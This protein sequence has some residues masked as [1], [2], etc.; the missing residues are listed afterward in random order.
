MWEKLGLLFSSEDFKASWS[1]SHT[2]LPYAVPLNKEILRVFVSLRNSDNKSIVGFADI[3][4]LPSPKVVNFSTH[5]VLVPGERGAFDQDGISVGSVIKVHDQWFFYY[6][7]WN[8]QSDQPWK[9][10]IGCAW[11]SDLNGP[12]K[13]F[14]IPVIEIG[15][16]DPHSLSYPCVLNHESQFWCWYGSHENWNKDGSFRHSLKYAQSSNGVQW[17]TNQQ[18]VIPLLENEIGLSRPSVIFRGGKFHCWFSYRGEKYKIGYASSSD[19]KNWCRGS[20][21]WGLSA[22]PENW[23]D[24]AVCYPH[25]FEFADQIYMLYNGNNYGKT[26]V[27]IARFTGDL[28]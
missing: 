21:K 1:Q 26:G 3:N 27:G 16:N 23:E 11:A 19:G 22:G 12:F 28:T 7:G 14:N 8:L 6:M 18:V 9:N 5:P 17:Q 20:H 25:V 15:L 24:E 4:L 10:Q 13:K 2:S